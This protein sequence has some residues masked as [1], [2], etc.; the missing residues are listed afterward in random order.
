MA[1]STLPQP[2]VEFGDVIL[3]IVEWYND[4]DFRAFVIPRV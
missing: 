4:T 3:L 1:S 2:S